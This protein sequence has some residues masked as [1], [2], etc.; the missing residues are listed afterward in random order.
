MRR[1]GFAKTPKGR[2]LAITSDVTGLTPKEVL[3]MDPVERELTISCANELE[4][5]RWEMW[6]DLFSKLFSE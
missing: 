2:S 4:A 1:M 3:Q 6:G 5:W